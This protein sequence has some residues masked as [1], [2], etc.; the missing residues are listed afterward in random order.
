MVSINT[1]TYLTLP[2][3][4]LFTC[5]HSSDFQVQH[6][7][8]RKWT[9][10]SRFETGVRSDE[11][12]NERNITKY[13]DQQFLIRKC[14]SCLACIEATIFQLGIDLLNHLEAL[15]AEGRW[16]CIPKFKKS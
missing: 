3:V 2:L 5:S 13:S 7:K 9:L 1:K 15:E 10:A 12:T 14:F 4:Y 16:K 8:T 6:S 11:Q